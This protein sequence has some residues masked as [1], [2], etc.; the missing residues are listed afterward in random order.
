MK[1]DYAK[2]GEQ[3]ADNVADWDKAQEADSMFAFVHAHLDIFSHWLDWATEKEQARLLAE[4]ITSHIVE[5]RY[6]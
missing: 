6:D 5:S 2:L 4:L 1:I 3:A